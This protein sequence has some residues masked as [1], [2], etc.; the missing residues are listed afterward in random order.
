LL[1]CLGLLLC[2]YSATSV[3]RYEGRNYQY[4]AINNKLDLF[5][6]KLENVGGELKELN[7]AYKNLKQQG[8]QYE[9]DNSF[10]PGR[11]SPLLGAASRDTWDENVDRC[12]WAEFE[13]SKENYRGQESWTK[14]VFCEEMNHFLTAIEYSDQRG[15]LV[16]KCCEKKSKKKKNRG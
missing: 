6:S 5:I 13:T 16:G 12:R 11:L 2:A 1:Q 4:T 3:R 8:D 9:S 15:V 7:A 10:E 14:K